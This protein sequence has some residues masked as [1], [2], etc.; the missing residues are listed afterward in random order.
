MRRGVESAVVLESPV[1]LRAEAGPKDGLDVE[2]PR[3]EDRVVEMSLRRGLTGAIAIL[4][5]ATL[6]GGCGS[7]AP[8][9]TPHLS[10]VPH[11]RLVDRARS[12]TISGLDPGEHVTLDAQTNIAGAIWGSSAEYAAG[13]RGT[14]EVSSAPPISGAYRAASVMGPFWSESYQHD[15]PAAPDPANVTTLTATT[16]SGHSTSVTVTQS[17]R[18]PGVNATRTTVA[19]QGFVGEYFSPP[20]HDAGG[21]AMISGADPAGQRR[22]RPGMALKSVRGHH[23]ARAARRSGAARPPQLRQRRAR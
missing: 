22:R 5:A 20:K 7:S 14:V 12:I 15:G 19:Q 16:G 11:A 6:F 2:L 4:F 10:V 9:R 18:A 8:E 13:P 3:R 23:R 17:H 21:P 1:D